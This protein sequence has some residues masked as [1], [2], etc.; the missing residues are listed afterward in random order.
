MKSPFFDKALTVGRLALA[1]I[2]FCWIIL[3]NFIVF[4]RFILQRSYAWSDEV[5]TTTFIWLIFIGC[6]IACVTNKHIEI[7]ILTDALHGKSK[8]LLQII[9]NL[10]MLV[11]IIILFVTSIEICRMQASVNQITPILRLP[12]WSQTIA[13]SVGSAAWIVATIYKLVKLCKKLKNPEVE[14]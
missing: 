7:T 1:A 9:Q 12:V 3:E 14:A 11:F 10:L 4:A 8:T 13:M 5:F 2:V 6:A